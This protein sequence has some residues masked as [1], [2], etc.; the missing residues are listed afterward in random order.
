MS[1]STEDKSDPEFT[2]NGHQNLLLK[3]A[4]EFEGFSMRALSTEDGILLTSCSE[5]DD[6]TF[7]PSSLQSVDGYGCLRFR[8]D[9][10]SGGLAFYEG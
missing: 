2:L 5:C 4:A 1:E 7:Q 6:A 9:L 10:T 3:A 8:S